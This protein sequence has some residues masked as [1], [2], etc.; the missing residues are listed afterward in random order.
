MNSPPPAPRRW[1]IA[2]KIGVVLGV[3]LAVLV[4]TVGGCIVVML[5]TAS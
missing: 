4:I 3:S 2:R 5:V 1:S